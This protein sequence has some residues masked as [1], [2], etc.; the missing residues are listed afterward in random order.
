MS[1]VEEEGLYRIVWLADDEP[2]LKGRNFFGYPIV[3]SREDLLRKITPLEV[4]GGLV[5]VGDNR[6]RLDAAG[7]FGR[8]GLRLVKAVH[9]SAQVARGVTIDDG[10]VIM[11]GTVV[12]A[13]SAIGR[14][15]IINTGATVDHDC[16]I[17]DGV[18]IAPGCHLCGT[19][20]VGA[21]SFVGA[22]SIVIP[23][24]AIGENVLIGAGSVIIRD[25][26]SNVKVAGNPARLL[27][28]N[29][30]DG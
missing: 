8:Q 22:G 21:A 11:A 26:P 17:G 16:V 4:R 12:N 19:V 25:V 14:A 1:V 10:T 9:P 15:V 20:R 24:T 28:E 30:R 7:W 6:R 3:G 13:D 23:G 18:H 29:S 2:S 27:G 5:A